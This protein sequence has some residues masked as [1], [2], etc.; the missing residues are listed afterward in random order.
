ML[1]RKDIVQS[2]GC[3][4]KSEQ[5]R[6]F[7]KLLT[8]TDD[9]MN[10][11]HIYCENSLEP[12]SLAKL[13]TGVH[14]KQGVP[15]DR[16][17]QFSALPGVGLTINTQ[18]LEANTGRYLANYELFWMYNPD[19]LLGPAIVRPGMDVNKSPLFKEIQEGNLF[20][21]GKKFQDD[22]YKQFD[23]KSVGPNEEMVIRE[24]FKTDHFKKWLRFMFD[25]K[26]NHCHCNVEINFDPWILKMY[27]VEA[28]ENVGLKIDW[29]V[30]S[31]YRVPAGFRAKLIFNGAHPE[32]QHDIA[33]D[34]NPDEIIRPA[35][36]PFIGVPSRMPDDGD[37][38]FDFNLQSDFED[39]VAQGKHVKLTTEE[40]QEILAQI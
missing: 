33:W 9:P 31:V 30:P 17:I 18:P 29:V 10:H 28:F 37:P 35:T 13:L 3:Y 32:W 24:Y 26:I 27:A 12:D 39:V 5:W 11:I 21:W 34:F 22:F 7:I 6:N 8:Q 19:V 25:P 38:S 20:G 36:K 14:A 1:V 15:L 16:G 23:F 2:L 40:I 4:F